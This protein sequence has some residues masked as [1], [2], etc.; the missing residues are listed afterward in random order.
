MQ[1]VRLGFS[2]AQRT[3][4]RTAVN[5]DEVAQ[6][7]APAQVLV[8]KAVSLRPAK[9]EDAAKWLAFLR[10]LDED[11]GFMLFE[12]GERAQSVAR[13][14]DAIRRIDAVPG[15][16]LL[17]LW[18]ASGNVVGYVKGDVLPLQ[19]K[20][21]VMALSGALLSGYRGDTGRAILEIFL[22][23]VR[24]EGLIKRLEAVV[25]SNN[26]RMLV[27]ALSAGFSIES[28]RKNAV[29]LKTGMKDEYVIVKHF[30]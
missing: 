22:D 13:C 17:L 6:V 28:L 18:N 2:H 15:A 27:V 3:A 23:S 10:A 19:R 12:P 4:T 26:V 30:E 16:M 9:L 8:R 14:E 24:R 1:R 29:R 21:H 25:M 5:M 7:T 20:A 11:T